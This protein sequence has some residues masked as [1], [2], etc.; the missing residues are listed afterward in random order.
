M[1]NQ[2]D[3]LGVKALVAVETMIERIDSMIKQGSTGEA[4]ALAAE[5]MKALDSKEFIVGRPL[6]SA[7][8]R[9]ASVQ[10]RASNSRPS[11]N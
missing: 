7:Q 4:E 10:A 9:I 2:I 5:L 11:L 1:A 3:L 8:R 6:D